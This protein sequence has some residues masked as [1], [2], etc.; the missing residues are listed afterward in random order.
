METLSQIFI[1][2]LLLI[3]GYF[4][5]KFKVISNNMNHDMSNLILYIALPAM[6]ITSLSSYDF[7]RDMLI[8]SGKLIAISWGVYAL[9]IGLSYVIPKLIK[10]DGNTRDIF[11]FMVVFSNVGFM[12]YPVVNAVFGAAGIFYTALYNL[13]FNILLWTFG[14]TVISRPMRSHGESNMLLNE[15]GSFDMKVFLNPGIASVFIGFAMFLTSTKLPAPVY[16]AFTMVGN[17]TTP[18]SM[19]FVGSILADMEAKQI[20]TNKHV[21]VGS[22]VRLILLPMI[23]LVILKLF[24]LDNIMMGIPVIITAMPVAAN[25]AIFASKY[26]NDYHMGSQAVFI[27]T[28]ISML[29]IPL[30]VT[31]L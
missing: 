29:T 26:G 31:L 14:V 19:I 5:K 7:S 28:L 13:P 17:T 9:S 18:L 2:F 1:L 3:I 8:K 23:V 10:I 16:E 27:S 24:H 20:F 11:Q 30:I 4:G 25:C 21:F 15:K 6:I 12:G 22:M